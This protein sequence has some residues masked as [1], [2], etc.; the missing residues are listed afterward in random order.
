MKI[1]QCGKKSINGLK[2]GVSLCQYHY[3][4]QIW[5]KQW[6][7]QVEASKKVKSN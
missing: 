3:N 4:A 1:C 6:A 5:N 7:N 2:R